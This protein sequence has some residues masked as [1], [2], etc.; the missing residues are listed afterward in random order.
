MG[1]FSKKNNS[2]KTTTE[3]EL[4]IDVQKALASSPTIEEISILQDAAQAL[5]KKK[6]LPK[7]TGD[8]RTALTPLAIKS[9]LSPDVKIIYLKIVA[10][11][12]RT[13]NTGAGIGLTFGGM[14]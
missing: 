13:S 2:K 6:Y 10:E 5:K 12:Y 3:D 11:K 14:H 4:F 8:L 9:A 1:I 7:I